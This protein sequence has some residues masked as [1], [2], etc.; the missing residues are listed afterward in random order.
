MDKATRYVSPALDRRSRGSARNK[1]FEKV[2]EDA[3]E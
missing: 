2:Q 1:K 3:G